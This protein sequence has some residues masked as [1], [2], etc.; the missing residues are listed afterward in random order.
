VDGGETTEVEE[1]PKEGY[2]HAGKSVE[3]ERVDDYPE[4]EE[5]PRVQ[6]STKEDVDPDDPRIDRKGEEDV[7]V[8]SKNYGGGEEDGLK[9][10][11]NCSS[12]FAE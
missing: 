9:V 4:H 11:A 3:R 1:T 2:V 8:E 7:C 10:P 5:P 6:Q 12:P